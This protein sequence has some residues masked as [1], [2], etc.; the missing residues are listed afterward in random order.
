MSLASIHGVTCV[1]MGCRNEE[2]LSGGQEDQL[3]DIGLEI[4]VEEHG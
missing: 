3:I 2:G 4:P 1:D